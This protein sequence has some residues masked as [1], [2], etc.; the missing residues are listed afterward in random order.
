MCQNGVGW[1][2]A[3]SLAPKINIQ[4][5]QSNKWLSNL[6][7]KVYVYLCLHSYFLTSLLS[8]GEIRTLNIILS[9]TFTYVF[10]L[11][12][13][14]TEVKIRDI[15]LVVVLP[16]LHGRG[17]LSSLILN[18]KDFK[19]FILLLN[20]G[21]T[22]PFNSKYYI[23]LMFSWILSPIIWTGL[24]SGCGINIVEIISTNLSIEN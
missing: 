21:L 20:W 3:F 2:R 19:P 24:P 9:I 1:R 6:Y 12:I 13:Y 16:L 10:N 23:Y 5:K 18:L 8:S 17:K 4:N 15:T 11:K 22:T 7:W 14:W